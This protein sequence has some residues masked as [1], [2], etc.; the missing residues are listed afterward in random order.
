MVKPFSRVELIWSNFNFSN[1]HHDAMAQ[2]RFFSVRSPCIT[3]AMH[4]SHPLHRAETELLWNLSQY[5]HYMQ[6]YL[7][8]FICH[9]AA[10]V[11]FLETDNIIQYI[12]GMLIYYRDITYFDRLYLKKMHSACSILGQ[13]IDI[14][15]GPNRALLGTLRW[16]TVLCHPILNLVPLVSVR[17]NLNSTAP[18]FI[19]HCAGS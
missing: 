5:L 2:M 19:A 17:C 3:G 16:S 1:H 18:H 9:L 6:S 7:E 11:S 10:A 8:I 12:T 13:N 4:W 14:S 15:F